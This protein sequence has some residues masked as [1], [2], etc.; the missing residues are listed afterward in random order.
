MYFARLKNVAN[1]LKFLS[2]SFEVVHF[3]SAE[4]PPLVHRLTKKK[5]NR[6]YPVKVNGNEESRAT[7]LSVLA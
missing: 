6:A 2:R 3:A 4:N 7:L 5:Q 1:G